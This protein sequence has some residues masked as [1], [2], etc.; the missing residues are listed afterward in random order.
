VKRNYFTLDESYKIL[1]E[2]K[3]NSFTNTSLLQIAASL[4]SKK[5]K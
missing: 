1:S 5:R 3:L 4:P 2:D